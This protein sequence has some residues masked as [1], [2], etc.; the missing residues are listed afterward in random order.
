[1][2]KL[3]SLLTVALLFGA[4]NVRAAQGD[5]AAAIFAGGCF[6]C[7]EAAFDKVDGVLST[8][9]GYTGGRVADPTY[10]EVSAGG[11]GHRESVKVEYDPSRVSY[12]QL[13]D[14]FWHNIDPL[15]GRGQFCDKGSQYTSAI[16]VLD[17]RQRAA[18]AA[19][20]AALKASGKLNGEIETQILDA[21]PFY[22]AEEY[23][24]DYYEKNPVRYKLYR[25]SCGRDA[26]L[27]KLWGD[28]APQH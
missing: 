24:Q 11:T 6:W 10:E 7:M 28:E 27:E 13:L 5:K 26:R 20:Q 1:M 16:F 9:S 12:E 3:I 21:G 14:V 4:I 17:E 25:W 18:A 15:D 2:T 8:T 23:H 22:P 19:S